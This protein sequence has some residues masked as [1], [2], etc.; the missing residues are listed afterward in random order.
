[1]EQRGRRDFL[2][3]GVAAAAGLA[4]VPAAAAGRTAN[5]A[6]TVKLSSELP[7]IGG[8]VSGHVDQDPF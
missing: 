8:R 4:L 7:K 3:V 6:S 5:V 2:K 1:M